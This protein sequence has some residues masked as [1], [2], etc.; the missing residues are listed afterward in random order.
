[1]ADGVTLVLERPRIDYPAAVFAGIPDAIPRLRAIYDANAAAAGTGVVNDVALPDSDA[2]FVE[3]RVMV[4]PPAFDRE[5]VEGGW[6]E[7]YTTFRAIPPDPVEPLAL[8]GDFVDAAHLDDLDLTG[9]LGAPGS[10]TGPLVLPTGRDVRLE[11]RAAGAEDPAYWA[12]DRARRSLP[13]ATE[14]HGIPR[15]EPG[16]FLPLEPP[17][18]LRSDFLRN[19]PEAAGAAVSS[20]QPQNDPAQVLVERLA[21]AGGLV[22]S[23]ATLLGKPGERVVFCCSGLKH[24]VSPEGGA[25][26]L[27]H[28][29]ELAGAWVNVLRL[30]I[31][32]DWTWKGGLSPL[33]SVRRTL[34]FHPG[35]PSQDED[36]PVLEL[37]H[38]VNGVAVS[39]EPQRDRIVL[40]YVDAF[41]APSWGGKPY[42][43]AVRYQATAR[44]ESLTPATFTSDTML[45]VTAPPRQV[46]A[47][48]SAGHALSPY[49]TDEAYAATGPRTRML[50]F[51]MAEPLEDPRDA[52]FV[53]VVAHSPDP[54][55]LARAEAAADP[56]ADD[57]SPLDPEPIRVIVPGQG[58]DFAGLAAM[59][60]LIPAQGS[61][62]HFLVP[63]P[64]GT[65][66][67][68]PELLGFYSYEIRVGHDAGTPESPFWSTAQG[69]FGPTLRIEGV[70]HP[71]P[72]LSCFAT[73]VEDGVVA[74]APFAQPFYQGTNVLPLPPNTE[75]W[76]ALYVQVHQADR[77][78]MRNVLLDLR[79]GNIFD[80]P[81]NAQ[82]RPRE[83]MAE[84]QWSSGGLRGLL[85]SLGL[86]DGAPLSVLAIEV[87]PEPNGGFRDPLGGDLGDV[88]ILRTSALSPIQAL[89]C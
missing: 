41:T 3:V 15:A 65:G 68:S 19:D 73:R 28:A 59:Q 40:V 89:C 66:A 86:D 75:I 64:P 80:R 47:L 51:E 60:R 33:L 7:L 29:A 76:I 61:G 42:Q 14:L 55:L 26:T 77:A 23:G 16:F 18:A 72:P 13:I 44:L 87:L 81:L 21:A 2:R 24:R 62:R 71:P 12:G 84:V 5:G 30:E 52:Y 11:L 46:P 67:G 31:D 39:G 78:T 43:L 48:A 34:R 25:L 63:L 10:K 20:I 35:G 17:R 1:A 49:A 32:R 56:V 58:D 88:R 57:K 27:T 6:R 50:W 37:P 38:S 9:Q 69:R 54:L 85:A 83:L 4:R 22:A 74:T 79:R 53:R 36:L 82:G 45:P 70:Q 8:R